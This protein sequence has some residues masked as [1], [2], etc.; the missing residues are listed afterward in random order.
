VSET[1]LSLANG[2]WDRCFMSHFQ[3]L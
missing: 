3:H 1:L 2:N